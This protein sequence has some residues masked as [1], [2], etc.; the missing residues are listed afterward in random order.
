M[1]GVILGAWIQTISLDPFKALS[2]RERIQ[3]TKRTYCMTLYK[4]QKYIY[5]IYNYG[6]Q[7]QWLPLVEQGWSG[8]G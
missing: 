1:P 4:F 6:N 7:K 5:L 8:G 3:I 2:L